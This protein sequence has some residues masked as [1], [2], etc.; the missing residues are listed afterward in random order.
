MEAPIDNDKYNNV[1]KGVETRAK[2][3]GA[4]AIA[5]AIQTPENLTK[6][7][8]GYENKIKCAFLEVAA[9]LYNKPTI[10][11]YMI[12]KTVFTSPPS[13]SLL[14]LMDNISETVGV[15]D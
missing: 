8:D 15:G 12:H 5:D 9:R 1:G 2:D 7:I 11:R 4:E 3:E 6:I 14:L 13:P 10:F